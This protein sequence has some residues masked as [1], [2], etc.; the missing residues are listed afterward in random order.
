MKSYIGGFFGLLLIG[1][2]VV[3]FAAWGVSDVF[4]GFSRGTI[5]SVGDRDIPT[6]EFRYRYARELDFLSRQLNEPLTLDQ[7]RALGLDRQVLADML[8]MATFDQLGEDLGLAVSDDIIA[9]KIV[10]DPAFAGPNGRFDR[11]TF[12][13][14]LQG[15]G[16][17]EKIFVRDRRLFETR[18]QL[19]DAVG[20]AVRSPAS[21]NELVFNYLLETRVAEYVVLQM[22]SIDE[23]N[24]PSEEELR[25][26]YDQAPNIFTEPERRSATLIILDPKKLADTVTISDD[27]LFEEFENI[28]DTF[29]EPETRDVDQMV[30]ADDEEIAKARAM[31]AEGGTF[32][33]IAAS[34]GLS[35]EDTDLGS[36]T[37]NDFIAPE[38]ADIAFSTAE[39]ENSGIQEGP[40]GQV[41]LR[42]RKITPQTMQDFESVKEQIRTLLSLDKATEEVILISEKIEDERAQGTT[43]EGIARIYDLELVQIDQIDLNGIGKDGNKP[44]VLNRLTDLQAVLFENELGQDLPPYETSDGGTYWVRM[45][46]IKPSRISPFDE[47]R[48]KARSQWQAQERRALLIGLAEHFVEKG[49]EGKSL[50]ALADELGK[51]PLTSPPLLRSTSNETFSRE[52]VASLFEVEE[53]AFTYGKVG[54]GESL[55]VMRLEKVNVPDKDRSAEF[56][57]IVSEETN[58]FNE[59]LLN[60]L[61]RALQDGYGVRIDQQVLEANT[62]A[63][64]Q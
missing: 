64:Q 55:I 61:L 57:Q 20:N 3:A 19:L 11:P 50:T 21:M 36:V 22:D 8:A 54:F 63:Q 16:L 2:L 48:E 40:L 43:L 9:Q 62:S 10:S 44:E 52:A 41:I 53:G 17:T 30:L 27:E 34:L 15:N 56:A 7:G 58:R 5:A 39:G 25:S 37:R 26:F 32:D 60:Q 18:R 13:R 23:I 42:V 35:S 33:E 4:N 24:E 47:V 29:V 49:N 14:L 28:Q 38:L 45:D 46:G 1:L 6:N 12:Q 31:L 51:S 59:N